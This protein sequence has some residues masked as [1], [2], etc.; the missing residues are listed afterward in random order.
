M[1]KSMGKR[2]ISGVTSAVLAVTYTYNV[3]SIPGLRDGSLVKPTVAKAASDGTPQDKDG[4]PLLGMSYENSRWFRGGPL[5]VAGD[6]HIF[7]FGSALVDKHTNGNVAAP[8]VI[9]GNASPNQYIGRLVNVVGEK[10]E[11]NSVT[12]NNIS[13]VVIPADYELYAQIP[14]DGKLSYPSDKL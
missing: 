2:L 7:A 11:T 1:K 9:G 5:G 6:F 14:E 10:W 4:L 8:T 3:Q 13:D 12:L